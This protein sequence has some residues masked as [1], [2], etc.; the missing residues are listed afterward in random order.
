MSRVNSRRGSA[1]IAACLAPI[2]E[3]AE[4]A[5]TE[6]FRPRCRPTPSIDGATESC[7]TTL[8]TLNATSPT[9]SAC[10]PVI[11]TGRTA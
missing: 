1:F 9:G 11:I 6:D 8:P 3:V 5:D 7:S 4:P 2:A 10:L